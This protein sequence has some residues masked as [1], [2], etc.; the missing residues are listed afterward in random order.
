[1]G[2]RKSKMWKAKIS[3]VEKFTENFQTK[4]AFNL[5]KQL[6]QVKPNAPVIKYIVNETQS[7]S[8]SLLRAT[9]KFFT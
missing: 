6:T 7:R 1:M 2:L 8:S 5:M 9:T 3:E 4:T